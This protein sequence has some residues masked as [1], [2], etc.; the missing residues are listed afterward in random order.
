M[1]AATCFARAFP[2]G[3]AKLKMLTCH[4]H[5]AAPPV[6][7]TAVF[8]LYAIA[9]RAGKAWAPLPLLQ[10]PKSTVFRYFSSTSE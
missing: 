1:M 2:G 9:D 4:V 6:F 10:V 8:R 5:A 3:Q 7:G